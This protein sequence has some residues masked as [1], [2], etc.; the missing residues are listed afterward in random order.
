MF[1]ISFECEDDL[2]LIMK[3]HLWMFHRQLIVFERL[4]KLTIR[5]DIK[6]VHS[7]FWMKFGPCPPKC[8]KKDLLHAISSTFGGMFEIKDRFFRFKVTVDVQR[9]L[10][11]GIFVS[12]GDSEKVW[13]S[14]EYETLP[15]FCFGC[16]WMGH[17]VGNCILISSK[18]KRK[19][20]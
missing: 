5:E 7:P 19:V 14:F 6:L 13:I 18:E 16:G 8:D 15:T 1:L 9:L 11:R 12:V 3:G 4:S 2:E 20:S 10:R 17:G